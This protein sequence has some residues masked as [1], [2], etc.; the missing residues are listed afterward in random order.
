[1]ADYHRNYLRNTDQ[2]NV[3]WAELLQ[4]SGEIQNLLPALEQNGFSESEI[5][6]INGGNLSQL[7]KDVLPA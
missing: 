3:S 5:D 6:K 4:H 2:T 7:F 1:M